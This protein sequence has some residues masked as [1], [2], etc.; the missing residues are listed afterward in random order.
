M[1]AVKA[2]QLRNLAAHLAERYPGVDVTMRS[3]TLRRAIEAG[4][5]QWR[6]NPRDSGPKARR[7]YPG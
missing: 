2:R 3:R 6:D 5:I 1:R 4:H 7:L